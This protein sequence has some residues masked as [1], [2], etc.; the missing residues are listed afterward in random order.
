LKVNRRGCSETVEVTAD[1]EGFCSQAGALLL[2]NL[3]DGL[4]LTEGLGRALAPTRKR[5]SVHDDGEILRD[6]IVTL[7]QGG[8]HLC[9]LAAL[10]DQP[11]LFGNVASDSTAFRMLER[12]GPS[13]L[14]GLRAAR[15]A[16]RER[17]FALGARPKDLVLDVDATLVGSHSDKEAAAGNYKGG[18]GFHPMLCYLDGSEGALDG[19]LRPGNAG[20]NTGADQTRAIELGLEQLP[21]GCM[22]EQLLVRGDSAACVHEVIDFCREGQIRFSVG[23][24]LTGEVREA[25]ARLPEG[26]WVAAISQ[27]GEPVADHPTRPREAYVAELT[28]LLD[29][30]AWGQG[31]RLLC[32][33]ERAHPGAQ[34]SLID[35]DGWRHQAFLTDQQGDDLAELDRRHRAHAHVEQRIEDAQALGLAKLPFQSFAMNEAW[36]QLALCAQD[37][38]AFA[39]ALTLTGDLAR[40]KPETLRYR[41]LH[42]AGRLARSGRRTKLRLA[43]HWPWARDLAAACARLDAL[44]IPAG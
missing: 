2:T 28:D 25:I 22:E 16:A 8:E 35:T 40:A 34:L 29:L 10:R 44:P 36:M 5:R 17:A 24:D 13:E 20:S 33:R 37:L 30:S 32:R 18:F 27:D 42:Q 4:G 7:V 41:L 12:I 1:G 19:I 31:A 14:Q 23:H 26:A 21:E 39:K 3:A 6:L 38:L 9:D 11:D 15:K 43:R